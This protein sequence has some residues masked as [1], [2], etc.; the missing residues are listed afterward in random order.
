MNGIAKNSFP[1]TCFNNCSLLS[2]QSKLVVIGSIWLYI[3]SHD[4][5]DNSK[6]CYQYKCLYEF[7]KVQH[8]IQYMY[9]YMDDCQICT[10]IHS[11]GNQPCV[12]SR[13]NS[14][15][16]SQ[17]HTILTHYNASCQVWHTGV[18]TSCILKYCSIFSH[19]PGPVE[20]MQEVP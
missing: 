11:K 2:C 8:W 4:K 3:Q 16:I 5:N 14:I 6:C 13:G 12:T 1:L 15:A 18:H 9:I 7:E 10:Y 17:L 19:H 20:S